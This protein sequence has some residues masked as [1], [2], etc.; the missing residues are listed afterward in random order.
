MQSF[1]GPEDSGSTFPNT[2]CLY[3]G[4]HL[5]IGGV[6][7]RRFKCVE[8]EKPPGHPLGAYF[9]PE[10][11]TFITIA[12][13]KIK[14]W[15][16]RSGKLI[17]EMV[18]FAPSEVTACCLD[19]RKKKVLIGTAGGDVLVLN[20]MNAILLKAGEKHR[21]QVSGLVYSR[22][23]KCAISCGWDS[24]IHVHDETSGKVLDLV[25]ATDTTYEKE[26]TCVAFSS[27]LGVVA[28][29]SLDLSVRL[30]DYQTLRLLAVMKGHTAEIVKIVFVP[31]Y[32]LLLTAD[33]SGSVIFWS[34]GYP[35]KKLAELE[36]STPI[37][38]GKKRFK[39]HKN[40]LEVP[41]EAATLFLT[42]P[43]AIAEREL[44]ARKRGLTVVPITSIEVGV[45]SADGSVLL[46][47]GDER[48][49]IKIYPLNEFLEEYSI[50]AIH[51]DLLEADKKAKKQ[52]PETDAP[53]HVS[54]ELPAFKLGTRNPKKS[55]T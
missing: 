51:E 36:N 35:W 50:K 47:T 23:D 19:E 4:N 37:K 54:T 55:G 8:V 14:L 25:R 2:A 41:H 45:N 52:A 13:S 5:I 43:P 18:D 38:D 42:Q 6:N 28:V 11:S 30:F 48:G 44:Q 20:Y 33:C 27:S 10:N 46:I 29:G 34:T 40:H 21:G 22:K 53:S 15:N 7:V 49:S 17:A 16:A 31:G 24:K 12:E 9:N 32:Y 3:T 39:P 1:N 26:T